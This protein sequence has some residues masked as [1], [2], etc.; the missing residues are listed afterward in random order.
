[1]LFGEV[2]SQSRLLRRQRTDSSMA[3]AFVGF[4]GGS[5]ELWAE[6][7]LDAGGPVRVVE[8]GVGASRFPWMRGPPVCSMFGGASAED[9][10]SFRDGS[11]RSCY[12]S[13]RCLGVAWIWPASTSTR[14]F[15]LDADLVTPFAWRGYRRA[16]EEERGERDAR[17]DLG[18]VGRKPEPVAAPSGRAP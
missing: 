10:A 9:S 16:T 3:S 18:A 17:G 11:A 1:M 5:F 13:A 6:P 7:L 14:R 15:P 12:V 4:R 8:E 2:S